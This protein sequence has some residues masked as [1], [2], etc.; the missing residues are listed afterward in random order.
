MTKRFP[1]EMRRG[2]RRNGGS[3]ATL[4]EGEE[5]V[6]VVGGCG[7]ERCGTCTGQRS[8]SVGR[9]VGVGLAGG[10]VQEGIEGGGG[11]RVVG[12]RVSAN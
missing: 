8:K 12:G 4:L 5:N 7:A 9:F 1:P 3:C 2:R 10:S 11:T 6:V